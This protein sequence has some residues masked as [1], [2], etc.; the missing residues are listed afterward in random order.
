MTTVRPQINLASP[1]VKKESQDLDFVALTMAAL[2]LVSPWTVETKTEKWSQT[3]EPGAPEAKDRVITLEEVAHHDTARDCW[4]V[5]YDRVY[6]IT[7]FLEEHP[8]GADVMLEYAGQD[9]STAFRSS[10]HSRN[11]TRTLDRFLVGEL[12]MHERMYR[13]PGGMRLSDIPD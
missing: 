4:V 1:L 7:T 12:P 6:D 13:R 8:G 3:I 10:G 9:A 11:T 5:I 2:R